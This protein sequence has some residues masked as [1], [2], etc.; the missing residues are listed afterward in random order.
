MK[1]FGLAAT[2][3]FFD[4]GS[5]KMRGTRRN[6]GLL[7]RSLGGIGTASRAAMRGIAGLTARVSALAGGV[8][9][10]AA[11]RSF[12][13]FEGQM[14]AVKSVLGR[15]AAGS[16]SALEAKAKNLGETTQFTAVQ[17]AE[18][19]ENL[20]RAGFDADQI[21]GA[22][23]PTLNAAAAEGMDLASAADIVASNIKAFGLQAEDATRVAD[24]L[25]F[26]SAKT[27]T[28]MQTLQEGMKFA[29]PIANSLGVNL[30]NT[31]STLGLLADIGLKGSLSGTAFKNAMLQVSKNSKRSQISVGGLSTR[32]EKLDSNS[33]DVVGTFRNILKS[34]RNIKSPTDRAAAAMKVLGL[35][36]IGLPSAFEAALED[37]KKMDV[38]FQNLEKN[39]KG[40][41]ERMAKMRLDN[42]KGDFVKLRS[43][44]EGV[45]INFGKSIALAVGMRGGIKGLTATLGQVSK[46]FG[47]FNDNPRAIAKNGIAIE[48]VSDGVTSFAQNVLRAVATVRATFNRLRPAFST[49]LDAAREGFELFGKLVR[50]LTLSDTTAE[51]WRTLGRVVGATFSAAA[52]TGKFLV[53]VVETVIDGV[54]EIVRFFRNLPG[55]LSE[56]VFSLFQD[57][58][59]ARVTDVRPARDAVV[60]SGGFV[61]VSAGDVVLDRSALAGALTSSMRGGLAS[62]VSPAL[63]QGDPGRVTPPPAN[64]NVGGEITVTVP[65]QIDGRQVALA[66]G[67]ANLSDLERHG[68]TLNPGDRSALLQRGFRPAL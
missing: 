33:V 6:V 54:G 13:N 27:N 38:L 1:R 51:G 67:R 48:G 19:M 29:A 31:A 22:I 58:A 15:E 50:V 41:A 32:I 34:L 46:A 63:G 7:G 40:A 59:E 16:F 17:S 53:T 11:I 65:V 23:G 57:R 24:T 39:A 18:A 5:A 61:P 8:G 56:K 45:L 2:F 30:E 26:V 64:V 12:S 14:G 60:R 10:G 9:V 28:N 44:T 49:I 3:K 52:D 36:G 20:A 62:S 4:K 47:F 68:A 43:A 25:A 42:V 37:G 66:V 35:R 21:I 55:N